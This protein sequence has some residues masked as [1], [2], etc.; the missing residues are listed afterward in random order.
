[1]RTSLNSGRKFP[2]PMLPAKSKAILPQKYRDE[3]GQIHQFKGNVFCHIDENL[4][5]A[6]VLDVRLSKLTIADRT[7]K[8]KRWAAVEFLIL[9]PRTIQRRWTLPF[10]IEEIDLSK[11]EVCHD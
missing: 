11:Q 8:H 5:A 7:N 10:T 9:N 6:K 4:F 1:M 2:D 3:V